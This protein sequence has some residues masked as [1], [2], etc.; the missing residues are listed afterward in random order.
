[1]QA[2]FDAREPW[3]SYFLYRMIYFGELMSKNITPLVKYG[4]LIEGRFKDTVPGA[5]FIIQRFEKCGAFIGENSPPEIKQK[6]SVVNSAV[7][8]PVAMSSDSP[9]QPA[10]TNES[11]ELIARQQQSQEAEKL[12]STKSAIASLWS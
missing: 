6:I 4:R 2:T 12:A 5:D 11:A 3:G 8:I 9:S 7:D 1:M 10:L